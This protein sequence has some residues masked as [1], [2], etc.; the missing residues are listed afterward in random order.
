VLLAFPWLIVPFGLYNLIVFSK[1]G[2]VAPQEVFNQAVGAIR[3]ASGAI[4][5]PSLGDGLITLALMLLFGEILQAAA[6][7]AKS[8][9]DHSLSTVLF[10]LCLSEFI[11]RREAATSVFFLFVFITL[12]DVL[13]GFW[14]TISAARRDFP[15]GGAS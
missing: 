11:V 1:A 9:L 13:A 3:L 15:A 2:T 14:V 6:R 7:G 4:W 8:V 10:L 5:Y 12:I